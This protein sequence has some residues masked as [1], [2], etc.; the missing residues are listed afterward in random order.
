ML[1]RTLFMLLLFATL[2]E[3]VVHGV[4]ALAQAAL[5]REV[6]V[7]VH[8]QIATS[9]TLTREAIARAIAAGADPRA[10]NPEPPSPLPACRLRGREGCAIEG[11]ATVSFDG[12]IDSPETPSPCPSAACTI[13]QQ[14]NDAVDEG[15]VDATIRAA[16]IAPS[17]AT[18]ASRAARVRFRTLGVAPFASLVGQADASL[19]AIAGGSGAGDDGGAAPNGAAPGT[20]IDVLFENAATGATMPANVWRSQEQSAYRPPPAWSP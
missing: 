3:T 12:A 17:G 11:I 2:A 9:T 20:F 13:Y 16:A 7:A 5:R 8:D 1:L 15:L 10:P 6:L 18:L 19:D 14:A 4:G